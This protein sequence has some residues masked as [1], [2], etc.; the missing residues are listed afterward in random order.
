MATELKPRAFRKSRKRMPT[1]EADALRVEAIAAQLEAIEQ[2]RLAEDWIWAAGEAAIS[3]IDFD[4][5]EP[6]HD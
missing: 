3:R 2:Q 5:P 4:C 1:R 6:G